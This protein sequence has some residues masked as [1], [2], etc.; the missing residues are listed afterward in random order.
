MSELMNDLFARSE[1]SNSGTDTSHLSI[2]RTETVLSRYPVHILD[3]KGIVTIDIQQR[4]ANG[5][6]TFQWE[7]THNSKY[8]Q[9]GPLAYKIETLIINRRIDEARPS[10][11][12]LIKLGSLHEIARELGLGGDTNKVKKALLQNAF[13]GIRVKKTYTTTQGAERTFEFFDNRYGVIFVGEKLPDGRRADAVY[14][15]LHDLFFSFLNSARVRPLD[16]DY[17]KALTPG[18]QRFYEILSYEMYAAIKHEHRA[19]LLYSEYCTFAPQVRYLDYDHVKKQMYKLHRAHLLSGY[20]LKA[21]LCKTRNENDELDW[22]MFYTPGPKAKAEFDLFSGR[23]RAK[24]N[25]STSLPVPPPVS[26]VKASA[27]PPKPTEL[28]QPA[29]TEPAVSEASDLA[30]ELMAHGIAAAVAAKLAAQ[31]P[32]ECRRQLE[33]LPCQ[34]IKGA[35]AGFLRSA[36]EQGYG[37]PPGYEDRKQK[38][39]SVEKQNA[40]KGAQEARRGAIIEELVQ[41][42]ES[43]IRSPSESISDFLTFFKAERERDLKKFSVGGRIHQAMLESYDGEQK[44]LEMFVTY[45]EQRP[46]P[47]AALTEFI[48]RHKVDVLK[49]LIQRH[50]ESGNT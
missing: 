4:D 40:R 26:I 23:T 50:F 6:L 43:L 12:K 41:I 10:I 18:A 44:Q 39:A 42:V 15:L 1:V 32:V 5:H 22:E 2:I 21:Q 34:S 7:V 17:L 36:I 8:G 20:I 16:Y 31:N 28:A 13:A 14:L 37:V 9:P 3:P 24:K 19:R 29:P 27:P 49:K 25:I 46:C 11:P 48:A 47:I 45:Y 33:Y 35:K 30:K 38:T